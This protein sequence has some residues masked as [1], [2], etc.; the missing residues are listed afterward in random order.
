VRLA[1][2]LADAA[3]RAPVR[4]RVEEVRGLDH[5]ALVMREAAQDWLRRERLFR[6][7]SAWVEHR[8]E[9]EA[10]AARLFLERR[11]RRAAFFQPAL[12]GGDLLAEQADVEEVLA[13][14]G[15]AHRPLPGEERSLA[16]R[17][18]LHGKCPRGPHRRRL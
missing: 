4:T 12:L 15:E 13:F 14:R 7:R 16:D 3:D 1:E 6:G 2:A 18:R 11:S 17:A 5:R 8:A 10:A 9:A